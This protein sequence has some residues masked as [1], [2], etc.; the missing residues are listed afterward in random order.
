MKLKSTLVITVVLACCL[1]LTGCFGGSVPPK[2][3]SG[4]VVVDD[5]LYVGSMTGQV[6]AFDDISADGNPYDEPWWSYPDETAI[7]YIYGDPVVD[8]GSVYIGCYSG[9]VYVLNASR[10]YREWIY[11]SESYVGAIV[12][13]PAVAEGTLYFGS[14]DKNLY[15]INTSTRQLEW[16]PFETDGKIWSTPVVYNGT[17]Y[18][19]SFDHN[20]YALDALSGDVLWQFE[21]GGA[22]ASTPLIYNGAIYFGSL[23]RKFYALDAVTGE[24]KAGFATFSADDWFWGEAVE[25]NGSIIAVSLDGKVYALDA[26]SGGE[27]W[28]AEAG[29]TVRGAPALVD[30]FVIVGT[31]EGSDRG[32]LYCFNADTGSMAWEHPSGDE[33]MSAIHASIGEG[34]GVVYVHAANQKIYCIDV[35]HGNILW[36]ISTSSGSE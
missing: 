3:W 18:I 7:S 30:N 14:S 12:G 31:D 24:S 6:V 1:L 32:K 15:A 27:L 33:T 20:L 34:D 2:G 35:E 36:S 17:V 4:P 19:G 5:L 23:D 21:T 28:V 9:K 10:G 8:N 26:D 22:I 29:G 11:P 25:H 16:Q 13:S